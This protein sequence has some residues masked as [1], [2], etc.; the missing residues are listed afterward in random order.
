[1]LDTIRD[2]FKDATP[3]EIVEDV[4]GVVVLFA[5]LFLTPYVLAILVTIF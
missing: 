5:M 3:A 4:L 2:A 1:M